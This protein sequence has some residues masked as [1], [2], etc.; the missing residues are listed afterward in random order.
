MPTSLAEVI[1]SSCV[2]ICATPS[3]KIGAVAVR[4]EAEPA[5]SRTVA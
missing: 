2:A 5:P 4:I 1:F 3:V